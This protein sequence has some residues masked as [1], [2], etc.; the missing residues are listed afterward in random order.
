MWCSQETA[1]M[2]HLWQEVHSSRVCARALP[3]TTPTCYLRTVPTVLEAHLGCGEEVLLYFCTIE[4]RE[5][6]FKTC[7]NVVQLWTEMNS[8]LENVM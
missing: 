1:T 2:Q 3:Q 4:T 8:S 6:V 5:D 7:S